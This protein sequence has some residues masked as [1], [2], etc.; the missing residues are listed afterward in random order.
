[1]IYYNRKAV[2]SA[3]KEVF[4][5]MV[6]TKEDI[7][8]QLKEMNAPQDKVVLMHSSLRAVGSVEGGAEGLLRILISYFTEKGG[9]FCVPAHTWHNFG[10]EITLDMA[11]DDTC[12][13]AFSKVA[14]GSGLG[15]RSENPSHSLVV[16]GDRERVM[17]FVE[18][19]PCIATPTAADSCHGK[20]CA[21]GGYVLLV[22]VA[23]N[24]NTYL[25]SVAEMLRLPNRMAD[26]PI[27][28]CIRRENGELVHRELTLYRT[29]YV[30]DISLRFPKYE[31]AFRYHKCIRDGFIGDA[32][33]QLCDAA[34]MKETVAL[35]WQNSGGEDPLRGE[36]P[37]P[38]KWYC[39]L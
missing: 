3:K 9:L 14:I 23:H 36:S 26:K 35:I 20:L 8:R 4:A 16:F 25:H 15:F 27:P 2:N 10:K 6:Y 22:G 31:T 38:Q 32:P 33:T 12:L 5:V 30:S 7:F 39:S 13:G 28:T 37:I 34:G 24:R 11:S 1:M 21:W 18:D 29:D 19:E 17:K